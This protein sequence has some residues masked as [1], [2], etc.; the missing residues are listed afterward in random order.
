MG[1]IGFLFLLIATYRLM[2]ETA[3]IGEV[4]LIVIVGV[5]LILIGSEIEK[6]STRDE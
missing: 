3:S 1:C 5:I 6:Y 2:Y 4:L